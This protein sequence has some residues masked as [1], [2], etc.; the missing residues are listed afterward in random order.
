MDEKE[1]L[2]EKLICIIPA[3][4]LTI[5]VC[6]YLFYPLVF[7]I[8]E[9]EHDNMVVVEKIIKKIPES[10][11]VHLFTMYTMDVV[12]HSEEKKNY[13]KT[14][15]SINVYKMDRGGNK[16]FLRTKDV[17]KEYK[18]DENFYDDCKVGTVLERD[19]YG[20]WHISEH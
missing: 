15:Q 17:I 13:L 16:T 6:I 3:V 7:G 4:L 19:G 5:G 9:E 12:K 8:V 11:H 14:R 10:Y 2:K 20:T 1:T 18:V